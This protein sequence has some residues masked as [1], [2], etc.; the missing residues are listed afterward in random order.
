M[1][2]IPH[3]TNRTVSYE[4]FNAECPICGFQN[5]FN[6]VS[7]L[8]DTSPIANK[9]VVC[10]RSACGQTFC[11]TGDSIN[12]VHDMLIFDCYQL[13]EEKRYCYCVL[14]LAQAHEAFFS[15]Y[16]R[17]HLLYLP[18]SRSRYYD[19]DRLNG[20]TKA[21]YGELGKLAFA[22][23]RNVF[24]NRVIANDQIASLAAAEPIIQKLSDQQTMPPDDLIENYGNVRLAPLLLRLK[25]TAIGELRNRVVHQHAYRPSLTEVEAALEETRA[26]LF[27]LAH[28]LGVRGDDLNWYM[29]TQ[30]AQ[31]GAP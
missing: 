5:V 26:I 15:L 27:P 25:R 11:I 10:L 7:D 24:L 22:K 8:Q 12:S 4:N 13:K 1:D 9:Q 31:Q 14:N 17:V 3:A 20:L 18:F 6:R 2:K 29:H 28:L 21:L 30:R 16:M 19:L 23:L